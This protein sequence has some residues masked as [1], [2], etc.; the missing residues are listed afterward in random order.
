MCTP[1]SVPLLEMP[2]RQRERHAWRLPFVF[3]VLRPRFV[4]S[5]PPSHRD[6]CHDISIS[7]R[8]G[9]VFERLCVLVGGRLGEHT[10]MPY[11]LAWHEAEQLRVP[12]NP[13]S[14]PYFL[15]LIF[16]SSK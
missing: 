16:V 8:W 2:L 11:E 3:P 9:N 7:H 15:E 13:S 1:S 5:K 12:V 4:E 6:V 10:G 14:L